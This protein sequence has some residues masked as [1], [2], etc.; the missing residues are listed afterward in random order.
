MPRSQTTLARNGGVD[1]QVVEPL[2]ILERQLMDTLIL[3]WHVQ[4][5]RIRSNGST[6]T[7]ARALFDGLAEEVSSFI[8]M[9]RRRLDC[10][11]KKR[12]H[13]TDIGPR[14]YW[15]LFPTDTLDP[16]DQFETLISAYVHYERQTSQAILSLERSGDL[17]SSQLL[18]AI[19]KA[20]E[21]C[22]W[23][24]GLYLEDLAL[25]NT[26]S[27]LPDW[28]GLFRKNR[29]GGRLAVDSAAQQPL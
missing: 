26:G 8:D 22:L 11:N 7:K 14:S 10:W 6:T 4:R 23:F 5:V 28:Q 13:I 1:E 24:L 21:R 3:Q 25:N 18:S 2:L 29:D 9:I 17:E 27:Y 12:R 15:R 16:H 20:V 19:S